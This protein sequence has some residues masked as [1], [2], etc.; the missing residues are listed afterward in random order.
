M[1]R[2]RPPDPDRLSATDMASRGHFLTRIYRK[3]MILGGSLPTTRH[4]RVHSAPFQALEIDA[5]EPSGVPD[6]MTVKR[7]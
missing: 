4:G 2:E 5:G 1:D 6:G 7:G 3:V